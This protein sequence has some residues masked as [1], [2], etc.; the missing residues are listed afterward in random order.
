MFEG[1]AEFGVNTQENLDQSTPALAANGSRE[2]VA[3]WVNTMRV[4][5]SILS[6]QRYV[7]H[8]EGVVPAASDVTAGTVEVV[9]DIPIQRQTNPSAAVRRVGATVSTDIVSVA[10]MQ[11]APPAPVA[12]VETVAPSV[13]SAKVVQALNTQNIAPVSESP[14]QTVETA[15]QTGSSSGSVSLVPSVSSAATTALNSIS[16]YRAGGMARYN[17]ASTRSYITPVRQ[18]ISSSIGSLPS[19]SS[20]MLGSTF[21]RNRPSALRISSGGDVR[22]GGSQAARIAANSVSNPRQQAA[23][24]TTAA[25]A[26]ERVSSLRTSAE[27]SAALARNS[28]LTPVP[29]G[30]VRTGRGTNLQWISKY[31]GRYQVQSSNDKANW[32]N[33]GVPRK[34]TSGVDALSIGNLGFRF[35]RVVRVN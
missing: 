4:D 13:S 15:K 11:I 7:V 6:A 2:F 30:V 29:A 23:V 10:T 17:V 25:T 32:G 21:S 34:G 24:A 5:H 31:G 12:V 1:G 16:Q 3:V 8:E 14:S 18:Q 33:V 26:S 9:G 20:M 22:L 19:R 28:S 27:A 35:Y